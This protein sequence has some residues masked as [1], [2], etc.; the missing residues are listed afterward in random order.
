[1][2]LRFTH[3]I[4][5]AAFLAPGHC[6]AGDG[7][8]DFWWSP[9]T[10]SLRLC[11]ARMSTSLRR[12]LCFCCAC[13]IIHRCDFEKSQRD[14][15]SAVRYRNGT[16]VHPP[17]VILTG[18]QGTT[19]ISS[20][21]PPPFVILTG[22]QGTTFISSIVPPPFVILTGRQRTTFISSIAHP[23]FV[24]LTGR[25]H[26]ET[27]SNGNFSNGTTENNDTNEQTCGTPNHRHRQDRRYRDMFF[28]FAGCHWP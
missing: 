14:S 28:V 16:T 27:S 25:R 10:S 9:V 2:V 5:R 17:F 7:L 22:R 8:E 24:I 1:M 3:D 19:F 12:L 23:P 18:R 4:A 6:A 21:V 26:R 13:C 20:I 15:S 11:A